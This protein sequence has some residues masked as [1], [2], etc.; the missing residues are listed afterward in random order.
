MALLSR[1][2]ILTVD[3]R[4]T[5]DVA[6]PEWGGTVRVRSLTGKERDAFEASLVDKKTG[7]ASKLANARARMVAMTV[8]DERGNR[9]FSLD[10]ISAL[11]DKSAA[12]LN[13][14]FDVARRLCGMSDD[15]LAE[16]VEDFGGSGD[17]SEPSTSD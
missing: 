6:V 14:V 11:G 17:Q 2:A 10:D 16:L 5:E 13:R 4:R 12:A 15:D 1:D 9:M 8:V 7:Q 3:D